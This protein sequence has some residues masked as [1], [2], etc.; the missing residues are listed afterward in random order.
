MIRNGGA[1]T[2]REV[3]AVAHVKGD[4][5]GDTVLRER[6]QKEKREKEIDK[7]EKENKI[8]PFTGV[9][10]GKSGQKAKMKELLHCK[11]EWSPQRQNGKEDCLHRSGEKKNKPLILLQKRPK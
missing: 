6:L 7:Q 11:E 2:H 4:K 3:Q 10:C 9:V 8:S 5:R 1:A